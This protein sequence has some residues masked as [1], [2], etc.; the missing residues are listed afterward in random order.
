MSKKNKRALV[1]IIT[2]CVLLIAITVIFE[3]VSLEWYIK[4]LAYSLP[5][6]IVGY[7][8]L[9]KAF[10][11]I[12]GGMVTDEN[13]LMSVAT[14]GA[15]VIGEY[16]EAVAVML[17]YQV[18]EFFQRI[19]VGKSRK[20][21]SSLMELRPDCVTVVRDGKEEVVMV[22]EVAVGEEII[23]ATGER[24]GLDGVITR[25]R[26]ALNMTA[27]TGESLPLEVKEGDTVV[28]ISNDLAIR[29]ISDV[30]KEE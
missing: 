22:E 29:D 10:R 13:F 19:A 9:K 16:P 27:L 25:G 28:F 1:R 12:I 17:F 21:I 14:I 11:N 15:F 7:D 23:V 5:Y 2:A 20:S 6:L 24:I 18:G 4:L 8:V 3:F 30:L 26:S